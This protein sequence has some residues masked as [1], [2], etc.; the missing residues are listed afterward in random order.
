MS[1]ISALSVAQTVRKVEVVDPWADT[2]VGVDGGL[3]EFERGH[4]RLEHVERG[5]NHRSPSAKLRLL[6]GI[7]SAPVIQVRP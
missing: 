1:G 6:P 7:R 3:A 2:I 4:S 5:I